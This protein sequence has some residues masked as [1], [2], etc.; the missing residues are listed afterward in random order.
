MLNSVPCHKDVW[1]SGGIASRILNIGSK[2][3]TGQHHAPAALPPDKEPAVATGYEAGLS[4]ESVCMWWWTKELYLIGIEP[5]SSI[6][7]ASY[8]TDW[9]L[10]HHMNF[11]GLQWPGRCVSWVFC[12]YKKMAVWLDCKIWKC[13]TWSKIRS[14]WTSVHLTLHEN[15]HSL[16]VSKKIMWKENNKTNNA[17]FHSE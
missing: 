8:D 6:P 10:S 11:H 4:L 17:L 13:V 15:A 5:R 3:R 12:C 14:T 7:Q 1:A 2:W 16:R 9:Q